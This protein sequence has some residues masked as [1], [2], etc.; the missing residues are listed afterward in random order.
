MYRGIFL[1]WYFPFFARPGPA[2]RASGT[3]KAG[4][5]RRNKLS[6]DPR[7]SASRFLQ[8]ATCINMPM[9]RQTRY[10]DLIA[11]HNGCF[12]VMHAIRLTALITIALV[13]PAMADATVPEEYQGV[14]A[15]AQ[16]CRQ[17]MQNVLPHVVNRQ[18]ATCRV[19][20]VLSS[21]R[22]G[23]HANTIYLNCGGSR[24]REIWHD[25]NID[26]ADFLVTVE[27]EKG[28][29]AGGLLIDIY[30][31][32]PEIPLGEIPFSDIPGTDT[33]R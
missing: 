27:F 3:G 11:C 26:G 17:K 33:R 23:W 10:P 2:G 8:L 4:V 18:N 5:G 29:E 13:T 15:S 16:D 28:G 20:Q 7:G 1:P 32:C 9:T 24:S 30:K 25:E 31:R 22:P 19:M 21:G 6:E 14:W 12:E